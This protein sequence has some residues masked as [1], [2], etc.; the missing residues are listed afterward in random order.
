MLER[1]RKMSFCEILS[2]IN[3]INLLFAW[4]QG[5]DED[6]P[7]QLI[8][9]CTV[10]DGGLIETL[11]RLTSTVHSSRRGEIAVLKRDNLKHFL[12]YEK[13][14]KRINDITRQGE[15]GDRAKRL[16]IAIQEDS[17]F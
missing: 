4:Q 13:V 11:E 16:A 1:Y 2:D 10:S 12:D 15:L 8:T 5:G 6:G 14:V 7:R 9:E 17:R 3:P